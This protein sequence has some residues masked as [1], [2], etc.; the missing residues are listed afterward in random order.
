M[1]DKKSSKGRKLVD[2]TI[3]YEDLK[4][5]LHEDGLHNELP[6]LDMKNYLVNHILKPWLAK[7][8]EYREEGKPI[9][10]LSSALEAA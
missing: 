10:T 2:L 4:K 3:I 9:P 8:E 5:A 7:R 1:S 6:V